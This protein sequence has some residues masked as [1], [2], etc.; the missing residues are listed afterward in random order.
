MGDPEAGLAPRRDTRALRW[1]V[2]GWTECEHGSDGYGEH[3]RDDRR[4]RPGKC[5][6]GRREYLLEVTVRA[7]T[8]PTRS[9]RPRGRCH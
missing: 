6:R 8:Y 1:Y 4:A 7:H 9:T 2:G 3:G 5:A